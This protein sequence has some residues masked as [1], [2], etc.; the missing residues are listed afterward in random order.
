MTPNIYFVQKNT[1]CLF[2]VICILFFAFFHQNNLA[3]TTQGLKIPDSIKNLNYDELYERYLASSSNINIELFYAK[4]YLAKA[5]LQSDTIRIVKGYSQIAATVAKSDIKTP[6]KYADSIIMLTKNN[7]TKEYPGYGYLIKGMC[8]T[9][10][11]DYEGAINNYIKASHFAQKNNNKSQFF[12]VENEIGNLKLFWGNTEEA[13]NIFKKQLTYLNENIDIFKDKNT[14]FFK[15][16]YNL[17]N[18]YIVNNKL[19]SALHYASLGLKK[20]LKDKDS[21]NYY[22]FLSQTG[23]I[24]FWQN[25]LKSAYDSISKA[26]PQ[27]KSISSKF[28]NNYLLGAI[29]NKQNNSK[30]SFYHFKKADSI[31]NV[32]QDIVPEVRIVQEYFVKYYKDKNDI[33]NQLVYIDRLIYVDSIISSNQIKLNR[34]IYKKFDIPNLLIEKQ[35]IISDLHKKQQI[36]Q[37]VIWCLSILTIFGVIL[38]IKI[39]LKQYFLKKK[40]KKLINAN[41]TQKDISKETS[42]NLPD[43]LNDEILKKLTAFEKNYGFLKNDITLSSLAQDLQTNSNYLSKTINYQKKKNFSTYINDLRIEYCIQKINN[44][45]KFRNFSIKAIADEIGFNNPE[46]FSK[47]FYKKTNIYPSVFIK[48]IK[49]VYKKTSK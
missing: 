8:L 7:E 29:F 38:I 33:K 45:T 31:Y 4:L 36:N 16:Y 22:K 1:K 12:Y 27:E 5:K 19:D 9:N 34:N 47:A 28:Y 26:M 49:K 30:K 25:D 14:P 20:G 40:I 43:Q 2:S 37:Y 11:G 46:S 18:S 23:E 10:L 15:V 42:I 6:L 35:Q 3:Q 17:S 21:Y 32:T 24:L 48:E 39:Y 44:N 41:N 13:L